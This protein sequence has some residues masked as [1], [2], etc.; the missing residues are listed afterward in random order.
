MEKTKYDK[1]F[2]VKEEK[3][4]RLFTVSLNG[5]KSQF[6]E[7]I[8]EEEGIVYREWDPRRSKLGAAIKN[9]I[10]FL[11][12]QKGKT[13]LYLGASNGYTPS[14]VSDILGEKGFLIGVDIAPLP[15][16]DL[17]FLSKSRVNMA[18]LLEDAGHPE[19]YKKKVPEVDI[20]YQDLAQRNQTE[21]FIKNCKNFLK[22]GGYG[23]LVI[24]SRS[25]DVT[26][27][28]R[29]IFNEQKHVLNA[30]GFEVQEMIDLYPYEKDHVMI[31]CKKKN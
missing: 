4:Q 7:E 26:R 5:K 15:V 29:E 27:N 1:V 20:V 6:D 18:P 3:L 24:K 28:P 30:S 19:N 25:I 31:V 16:R 11:P 14:F 17:Y 21:I 8:I 10:R 13:V 9:K 12:I 22:R 23:L 2:I